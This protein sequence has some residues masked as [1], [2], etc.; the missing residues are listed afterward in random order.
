M[1][2]RNFDARQN[3]ASAY[4]APPASS[5]QPGY[6]GQ[7]PVHLRRWGL[8]LLLNIFL[9]LGVLALLWRATMAAPL[10]S[11]L[12]LASGGLPL[13]I[14]VEQT[15]TPTPT[16]TPTETPSPTPTP[17][18]TPVAQLYLP[19]LW[20]D[21]P[22][23]TPTATATPS[24]WAR[25][26]G[27]SSG[28]F[29]TP[30]ACS[31]GSSMTWYAGMA[32]GGVWRS[33]DSAQSW[34]PI[35]LPSTDAF[36]MVAN[37]ADCSQAFVAV[38][39]QGVYQLNDTDPTAINAG[40]GE[41]YPYGLAVQG[42]ILYVGTNSQGVFETTIND[43]NWQPINNG[44]NDRRIR[45]LYVAPDNNTSF[46]AGSR[47]CRLYASQDGGK[48]WD[49]HQVLR[50]NCEDAQVWSVLPVTNTLYAGLGLEKGLYQ[51]KTEGN[52]SRVEDIP[53]KTIYGLAHDSQKKAL[54][55]STYG[56]GVYRCDLNG[57]GETTGC[58]AYNEGLGA[59]KMRGIQIHGGLIVAGSDDGIW[60][61]PLL[62]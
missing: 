32:Q 38:W 28:R 34:A 16:S 2:R 61:R 40:L 21:T 6:P 47:G 45:T 59:L 11:G 48:S 8:L 22:T 24:P 3:S 17:T 54:Y 23:A 58:Q 12:G 37:P 33:L 19:L 62:P 25:G 1:D 31:S 4:G 55:V 27:P 26:E 9:G 44:I 41:L 42:N 10:A 7:F 53:D 51:Q 43:I 29:Y 5:C 14:A 39:G 15:D 52:W 60:Y 30:S 35:A 49:E 18:M 46:Y 57:A 56:E 13:A 50:D 20:R 36:L